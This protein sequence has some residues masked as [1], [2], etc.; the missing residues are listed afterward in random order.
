MILQTEA[1]VIVKT[2]HLSLNPGGP[3]YK[4]D[5]DARGLV[6]EIVDFGLTW[7]VWDGKSLGVHKEIFKKF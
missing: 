4:S 6:V 5:R 1:V 7:E 3:P 2:S